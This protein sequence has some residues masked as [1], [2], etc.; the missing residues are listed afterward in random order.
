MGAS[1][2]PQHGRTAAALWA[3]QSCDHSHFLVNLLSKFLKRNSLSKQT[4]FQSHPRSRGCRTCGNNTVPVLPLSVT[5]ISSGNLPQGVLGAWRRRCHCYHGDSW[6]FCGSETLAMPVSI[7]ALCARVHLRN[8]WVFKRL[9]GGL[10]LNIP[11]TGTVVCFRV[12]KR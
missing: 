7:S 5:A 10:D 1:A 2:A 4:S 3:R 6:C 8:K 11:P 9:Y 12:L